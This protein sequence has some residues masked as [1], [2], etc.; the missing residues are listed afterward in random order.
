LNGIAPG[1]YKI[2]AWEQN[3]GGA[4]QDPDFIRDY[5]VLGTSVNVTAGLPLTNIQ[6]SL[7]PA[8]H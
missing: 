8:K 1:T 3:P 6:A 4:E 7:I 2:F 5:D